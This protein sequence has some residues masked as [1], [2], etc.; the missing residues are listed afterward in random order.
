MKQALH[1][2]LAL[3]AMLFVGCGYDDT[4]LRNRIEELEKNQNMKIA[5]LS[6]QIEAI[7]KTISDLK[8]V[9]ANLE[10]R[11][12]EVEADADA[13]AE[14]IAELQE[15]KITLEER[16][17]TLQDYVDTELRNT[18]DWAEATFAT[19]QHYYVLVDDIAALNSYVD[20]LDDVLKQ[21]VNKQLDGYYTI[22]EVN[23]Q[24]KALED[25]IDNVN[26]SL[27]NDIDELS[28][29]VDEMREELISAY[30]EAIEEAIKT[31]NG[32]IDGKIAEAIADVN[33][34]VD[35]EVA[36]INA[37]I[38]AL[39]E[40][41][42]KLEKE[43]N[44]KIATLQQQIDA[45]NKTISDLKTV[46]ANLEE[47]IA[48][49]QADVYANIVELE[50]AQAEIQAR[51]E[52]LENYIAD[53]K[54]YIE[55]IDA[56]LQYTEYWAEATFATLQQYYALADD[57]AALNSYVDGLDDV[58]KQWV[59]EQLDGYYTI[60][61]V[62]AMLKALEDAIGNANINNSLSDDIEELTERINGMKDEL[63]EAYEEAVAEAINT[64]SGVIDGKIADAIADINDR[65]D[66]EIATINA[67]INALEYRIED[68][69]EALDKIKALDIEFDIESG[70]ACMAGTSIEF[71][72]TIVG[73]DEDTEVESFGD[74][75]WRAD[76]TAIDANSG[77]IRVTAP[78]DGGN[79]KVIVL[80]TSGAGAS[81]MKS[82]RF[83]EGVLTDFSAIYH[84]DW[85][86]CTL[87]VRLKT[88]V[89]YEVRVAPY[90][91]S[92]LSSPGTRAEMREDVLVFSVA[93]NTG[94]YMRTAVVDLVNGCGEVLQSLEIV[95]KQK[96]SSDPIQFADQYAKM[97][98]VE[99]FDTNGDGELSYLE[100][101][102]V[103]KIDSDFFGDYSDYV[104]SFDE[105]QCF[106]NVT[107]IGNRAFCDCDNLTS[108]TIPD[109]VTTIGYDAFAECNSLTSV[110]IPE[111]VTTIGEGAFAA[112]SNLKEFT[113]KYAADGGRCLIIDNTIIA[114]ANASG[115]TYN[116][117]DSVTT[118]GDYAFAYCYSLTSVNIPDSITTIGEMAFW[119]CD[120]LTSVDIPESVTT[121]GNYASFAS[122][123]SLTSV[124]IPDSVTTIGDYAFAFCYSLTSVNIGNSITTIG[125]GA[126]DSCYSLT[127]VNIP[128]SV[129]TIG[130]Y[131]FS[132]CDS[133]KYVYCKATTPPALGGD[134]VFDNNASDRKI[135]VPMESVEAYKTAEYWSEYADAIVGYNF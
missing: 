26:D 17:A 14:D 10:E 106:V 115:T 76:V 52:A 16:I 101:S 124:N 131:A 43:Q 84:V 82:I 104:K 92:W 100:A 48:E 71:G 34:R 32:V 72:Y 105:F 73:G 69:E 1:L 86:A 47:R 67:R 114:Y 11:I 127:S 95:Q 123:N 64:N 70:K 68:L 135:Y 57:V 8:T 81:A 97:V 7:N 42:D 58:L 103:T 36:T 5:T 59:N 98:C 112:C 39:E 94:S 121:I 44:A 2:C 41:I 99:K 89:D 28:E 19:L 63:V 49:A 25:A 128:D 87:Y 15:A 85:E 80:A 108:V 9:N 111:S 60:A 77:R 35:S 74:G 134:T 110:D 118:I 24:L 113:G 116:I 45:I 119:D 31:N 65:I 130:E 90:A 30:E 29:K 126:F 51:I 133:L 55:Y 102:K 21:W 61:E 107:T 4:A 18:E 79:G 83:E 54:N 53:L 91:K 109:S 78:K 38:D 132:Y 96:P 27:S 46:N 125:K 93:E 40:R 33:D 13:N 3:F 88:N 122:C 12:A 75:G 6:E 117:P 37:R 66:S 20:G 22:A 129:T 120:S 56:E 62:N 50:Y 23:A